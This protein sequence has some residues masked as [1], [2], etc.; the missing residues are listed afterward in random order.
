LAT[1]DN[2][3]HVRLAVV[4]TPEVATAKG[5][6]GDGSD[7]ALSPTEDGISGEATVALFQPLETC[8]PI[9][10]PESC[11]GESYGPFDC[12]RVALGGM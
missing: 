12:R 8:D 7:W 4:L 2:A 3:D 1:A 11:Q 10:A 5:P 9:G 6:A